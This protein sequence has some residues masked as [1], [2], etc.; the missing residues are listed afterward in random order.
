MKCECKWGKNDRTG[1]AVDLASLGIGGGTA[2]QQATTDE[3]TLQ[4]FQ[5]PFI[6]SSFLPGQQLLE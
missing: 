4:L 2:V 1:N 3:V 5:A 6:M